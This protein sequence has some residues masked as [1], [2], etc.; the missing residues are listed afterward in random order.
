MDQ[1]IQ[2]VDKSKDLL[3]VH[4]E[5]LTKE[6]EELEEMEAS[7]IVPPSVMEV[8]PVRKASMPLYKAFETPVAGF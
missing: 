6:L 1:R 3:V 8:P 2:M 7:G 4:I 5:K